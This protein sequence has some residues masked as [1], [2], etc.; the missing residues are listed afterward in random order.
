[1]T[2]HRQSDSSEKTTEGPTDDKD[3]KGETGNWVDTVSDWDE[4]LDTSS[5][6]AVVEETQSPS[7]TPTGQPCSDHTTQNEGETAETIATVPSTR[8][9]LPADVDTFIRIES[10]SDEL[11]DV[12][13]ETLPS[14]WLTDTKTQIIIQQLVYRF[15]EETSET[16]SPHGRIQ[17]VYAGMSSDSFAHLCT[18][19]LYDDR[20]EMWTEYFESDLETIEKRHSQASPKIE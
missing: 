16:D 17:S 15:V 11:L 4:V 12:T 18:T 19:P 7:F 9:D 6:D 14:E 20:P 10:I 3:S 8:D 1:M 5:T 13:F 2:T